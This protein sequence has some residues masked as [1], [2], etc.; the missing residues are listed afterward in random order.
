MSADYLF[1]KAH[2]HNANPPLR[3]QKKRVKGPKCCKFSPKYR[4]DVQFDNC[5]LLYKF[6]TVWV[7]RAWI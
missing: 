7:C 2:A 1:L 5:L 6:P 3:I 4:V